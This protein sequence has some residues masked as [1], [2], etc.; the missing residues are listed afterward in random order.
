MSWPGPS[1]YAGTFVWLT[2]GRSARDFTQAAT[3]KKKRKEVHKY[4]WGR[5]GKGRKGVEEEKGSEGNCV[6]TA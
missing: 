2:E 4:M 6:A 3:S 1:D 5:W